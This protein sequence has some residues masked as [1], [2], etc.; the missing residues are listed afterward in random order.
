[1]KLATLTI[2]VL[3][4][5]GGLC[6]C[7]A[8]EVTLFVAPGGD[9]AA[10]GTL[11]APLATLT[12]ARDVV[13][14]MKR[15]DQPK[16]PATI[17]L[18]GGRYELT[19]PI[20]FTPADSG[21]TEAPLII[22][23]YQ[24]EKPILSGGRIISQWEKTQ[25]NGREVWRAPLPDDVPAQLRNLWFDGRRLQRA[26]HPNSG[27]LRLQH[28]P[29]VTPDTPWNT[30]QSSFHYRDGDLRNWQNLLAGEVVLMSRWVEARLP[31]EEIDEANRLVRFGKKT[32]V[33]MQPD[34][35][36]YV[37]NLAELLDEP[38]EY[39]VDSAAR[40]VFYLPQHDQRIEQFAPI[41][42]AL[43]QVM[44]LEGEPQNDRFV[45]HIRFLR[46][47]FAHTQWNIED[48]DQPQESGFWQ[49]AQPVPAAVAGQGVRRCSFAECA[50][51]NVG[52]YGLALSLG[53]KENYIERCT[54][55]DLGAGGI[56]LGEGI[57]ENPTEQSHN[58]VI[59]D[60][61][62]RDGG[63]V[64]HSAVGIWIGHAFDN[65]IAHNE[66]ADFY[67]TAISVG[68]SWGYGPSQAHGNIIEH[69]HLHHIGH[70]SDRP[71][72]VLSDMG[73]IYTLGVQPGTVLRHNHIHDIASSRYGGWGIYLD[74][75]ST[76]ILVENNLVYRTTNGG[77]HQHYGRD[78]VVRNNIFALGRDV[79]V[80]R[81]IA[82]AHR[83]FSFER[84]IVYWTSGVGVT[85][86]FFNANVEFNR[87][88]YFPA[89]EG[90]AS[91]AGRAFEQ[92]QADGYDGDSR[93]TDPLFIDPTGSD[94]RLRED[95]PAAAVGFEPFT[96]TAGPR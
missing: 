86:D 37:E 45:E 8:A 2:V 14:E 79:Q 39:Y 42:P 93:L 4:C 25:L 31:L 43:Q 76:E 32:K 75:G 27:Y 16:R 13:R 89:G 28:S 62:I 67:Y 57:R 20:V 91:F 29:E 24:D 52:T 64:Y 19:E 59:I 96:L 83:S 22:R 12:R 11:E 40:A 7:A 21:S 81:S 58:N 26:R 48:G 30:G 92:W 54:L 82:E 55:R 34:D 73:G 53:C 84:N 80:T 95:S 61:T 35:R 1:M 6:A 74:E 56:K 60:C 17:F 49:A 5:L 41:A 85:G 63:N 18:R 23:A 87:N 78:N 65:H 50:I 77:F 38:G 88:V 69:N 51:E 68:W 94:F 70:R 10:A 36:Y 72:P 66:I 90:Q 47:G 44:R 33:I 3:I 46:I 9:D 71:E 15:D